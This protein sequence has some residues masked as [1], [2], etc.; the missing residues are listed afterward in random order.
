MVFKR[1]IFELLTLITVHLSEIWVLKV[2]NLKHTR[3]F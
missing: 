3:I 2:V 1:G